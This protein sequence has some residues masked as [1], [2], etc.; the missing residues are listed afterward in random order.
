MD[1]VIVQPHQASATVETRQAM[2]DLMI[3]NLALHFS[4]QAVATP[5]APG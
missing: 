3:R 4:G 2:G 1:N 5:V